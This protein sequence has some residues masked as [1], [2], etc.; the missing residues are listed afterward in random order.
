MCGRY[1]SVLGSLL[2]L[3]PSTFIM[4]WGMKESTEFQNRCESLLP[5]TYKQSYE[6]CR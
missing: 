3:M 6:C 1:G 5:I 4:D 2:I